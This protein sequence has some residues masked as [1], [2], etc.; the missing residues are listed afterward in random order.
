MI[1][2]AMTNPSTAVTQAGAFRKN[3][4]TAS[5]AEMNQVTTTAVSAPRLPF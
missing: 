1:V 2:A 4:G 5:T 3:A